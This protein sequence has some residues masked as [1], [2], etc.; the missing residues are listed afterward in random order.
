MNTRVSIA[1]RVRDKGGLSGGKT[2]S[3]DIPAFD[4][5]K[6]MATPNAG[7]FVKKAYFAAVKKLIREIKELK[8]GSVASNLESFET[9]V[10]RSLVF[11]KDEIVEW[12]ETRDWTRAT[13]VKDMEKLLPDIKKYLPTLAT[14]NHPFTQ[15]KAK[16]LAD[17]VIA[18][19]ADNP[20]PIAD[21]LFTTLTTSRLPEEDALCPL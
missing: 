16:A 4:L 6:F 11:T 18:A 7:E 13:Q 19:V 14:R 2:L 3:R 21:F 8:N 15:E 17:K 1:F 10:A 20:D 9:I 5:E 12:I